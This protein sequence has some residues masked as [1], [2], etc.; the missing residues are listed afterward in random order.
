MCC[1]V[2]QCVAVGCSGVQWGGVGCS[3]VLSVK[4]IFTKY[5]FLACVLQWVAVCCSGLQWVAV[6]CSGLQWAAVC[7]SG[8][9]WGISS[10]VDLYVFILYMSEINYWKS[11]STYE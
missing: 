3:G 7:C 5:S 1:N 6:G 8:V 11:C 9:Q 4:L 10:E 2:L